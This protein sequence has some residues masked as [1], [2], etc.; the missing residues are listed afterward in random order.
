M[1]AVGNPR[2]FL[3]EFTMRRSSRNV[4][5]LRRFNFDLFESPA[6]PSES[7][8]VTISP[9]SSATARTSLPS[10]ERLQELFDEYNLA[11]FQ[12]KLPR[13]K[14]NYSV[15]L[16]GAGLYYPRSQEIRIGVKYHQLFPEE[17]EDTLKHE[18]IHIIHPRHDRAF[19]SMAQRLGASLKARF[20]PSLRG[21]YRYLY[22]CPNCQ[23]EYPRRKRLRMASCGVCSKGGKFDPKFKLISKRQDF[24]KA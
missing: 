19:K 13:V 15:R 9:A 17:I 16:L 7:V 24:R 1:Q 2:R 20:H 8:P 4:I 11:F 6:A 23:R 3:F 14:I 18:M 21:R 10:L 12:G 5:S 22:Y